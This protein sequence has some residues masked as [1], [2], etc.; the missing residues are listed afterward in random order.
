MNRG[1]SRTVLLLALLTTAPAM[2]Q[3]SSE[4][5]TEQPAKATSE[6]RLQAIV[7]SAWGQGVSAGRLARFK[8]LRGLLDQQRSTLNKVYTVR[9]LYLENGLLQP[10]VILT[11][12]NLV[13]LDTNGKRV[14]WSQVR[15]TVAADARFV[16]RP[17][18][19]YTFLV[20][21]ADLV[22][23]TPPADPL[24]SP[25]T[26]AERQAVRA[27]EARGMQEGMAQAD[28]EFQ[29]RTKMLTTLVTG[30]LNYHVLAR[31]GVISPPKVAHDYQATNGNATQLTLGTRGMAVQAEA[32]FEPDQQRYRAYTMPG[33]P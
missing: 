3:D 19:W 1:L 16:T 9:Q 4:D 28:L 5:A 21:E 29:A 14:D 32:T 26:D 31:R 13:Q 27:A 33:K 25:R 8:A 17:L 20:D 30:M 2:A 11:A 10:P 22:D 15:Y 7:E 6:L 12:E 24:L 18:D 23:A